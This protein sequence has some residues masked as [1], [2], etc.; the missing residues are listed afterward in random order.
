MKKKNQLPAPPPAVAGHHSCLL[1]RL[2][3]GGRPVD[4]ANVQQG[5]AGEYQDL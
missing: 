5:V 2:R 1:A 4:S 3:I